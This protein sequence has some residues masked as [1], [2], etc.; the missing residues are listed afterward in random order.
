MF[1][2]RLCR[3]A[4][5]ESDMDISR[6]TFLALSAAAG[7]GLPLARFGELSAAPAPA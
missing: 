1:R 7:A 5:G 2:P 4:P 3:T 6:R